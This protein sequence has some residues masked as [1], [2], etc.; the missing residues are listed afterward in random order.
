[1]PLRS[2]K[3]YQVSAAMVASR[4][5]LV[6]T[7]NQSGTVSM[8]GISTDMQLSSE[9][10]VLT[11]AHETGSDTLDSVGHSHSSTTSTER[12]EGSGLIARPVTDVATSHDSPV[13]RV[14]DNSLNS[15][16]VKDVLAHSLM[17]K[18]EDPLLDEDKITLLHDAINDDTAYV[19]TDTLFLP[20]I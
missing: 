10:S 13:P 12:V 1:M 4:L 11:S 20:V 14:E 18:V 19:P 17:N 16:E 6:S 7:A 8:E 9:L 3:E 15:H 5:D 2:G